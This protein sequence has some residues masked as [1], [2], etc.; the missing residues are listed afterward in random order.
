MRELLGLR[1]RFEH[2]V[3]IAR[4]RARQAARLLGFGLQD[5]TRVATAV[6]ELARRAY[7]AGEEGNV[8]FLADERDRA[9]GRLVVRIR[10]PRPVEGVDDARDL[11]EVLEGTRRLLDDVTTRRE[12]GV[13]E[14]EVAHRRQG[15]GRLDGQMVDE[16][17][18]RLRD[19][20]PNNPFE[21][22]Q[23]QNEELVSAMAA[24]R[25]QERER[26]RLL[27]AERRAR[28][29][30]QR[31]VRSRE[32]IL[33]IV[34]HDLR[35]PVGAIQT[36]ATFL[37]E[38]PELMGTD[39]GRRQLEAMVRS[40]ERANRLIQDLLDLSSIDQGTLS[41]RTAPEDPA[42]V[43][44]EVQELMGA[45]AV[46]VGV[47]LVVRTGSDLPS[48]CADRDRLVQALGNLVSNALRFTPEGGRVEVV[49]VSLDRVVRF[50]VADTGPGI[51]E[52]DR[53][54]L[55]ERFWSSEDSNGGAGL[56]L[57]IVKGI[58][59]GH[60][61]DVWLDPGSGEGAVFHVTIPVAATGCP[62]KEAAPAVPARGWARE[63]LGGG[64]GQEGR[65]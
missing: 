12:N 63:R 38:Q 55:F 36:G 2:D 31:A 16:A 10:Y 53:E 46:D 1:L 29:E 8:T 11:E 61:G 54:H 40:A 19:R 4:Q 17:V 44:E 39:V 50:T 20:S 7:R 43:L 21:E 57:A 5:Q 24:L 59:E 15:P 30:A 58:V 25:E 13:V 9:G 47:E 33:S 60:G 28:E 48:V 23:Q 65:P 37:L 22:L 49:A 6:S 62:G 27:E 64:S 41:V 45:P 52:A 14:V 32:E 35:N 56:G 3:V 18:R 26:T 42:G 34:S 51:R